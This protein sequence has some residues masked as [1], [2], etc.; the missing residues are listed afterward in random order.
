M[1]YRRAPLVLLLLLPLIVIGFW[2]GYFSRLGEAPVAFHVHALT[3]GLWVLLLIVQSWAIHRGRIRLH[4]LAGKGSFVIFPFFLVGGLMVLQTM[5]VRTGIGDHPFMDLYGA[6]LGAFDT[7]TIAAFAAF[8]YAALRNRRNV[9]LHAR[10]MLATPLLLLA[11][12]FTRLAPTLG[13]IS[14]Q[15]LHAF[16]PVIHLSN[17]LTLLIAMGLFATAPRHGRPFLMAAMVVVGQSLLFIWPGG[18][19]WWREIYVQLA[20]VPVSIVVGAGLMLG[21]AV[22]ILAMRPL[23]DRPVG[24]HEPVAELS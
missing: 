14:V 3:A 11:P 22:V 4:R 7:L 18:A 21:V 12:I 8:Y 13:L 5:A 6:G 2:Q 15:D 20:H 19:L 23:P 16:A 1:P 9:Q 24:E 17:A 10:Y